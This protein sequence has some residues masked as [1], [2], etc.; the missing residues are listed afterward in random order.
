MVSY[1]SEAEDWLAYQ[2]EELLL[3]ERIKRFTAKLDREKITG[4]EKQ[5]MIITYLHDIADKMNYKVI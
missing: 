3:E 2:Q 1:K 5:I 4:T